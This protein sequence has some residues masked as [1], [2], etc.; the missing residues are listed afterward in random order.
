MPDFICLILQFSF[1]HLMEFLIIQFCLNRELAQ[2]RSRT[3]NIKYF[4]SQRMNK[5]NIN[6]LKQAESL[7]QFASNE[8]EAIKFNK[9][10]DVK[11]FLQ[12][13]GFSFIWLIWKTIPSRAFDSLKFLNLKTLLIKIMEIS[14]WK[15]YVNFKIFEIFFQFINNWLQKKRSE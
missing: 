4:E 7:R 13:Y 8:R 5:K 12:P 2:A 15:P 6:H 11:T 14:K 10:T 9:K 1:S 3:C